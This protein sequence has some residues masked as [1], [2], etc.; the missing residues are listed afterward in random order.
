MLSYT[1]RRLLT[2]LPTL[3]LVVTLSFFLI[4]VAPG[5]PFDLERPLEAKVMENLNRIYRLDRPL[6]EQYVS[7]LG[8][9]L[10]G[11]FGPSFYM[12]DFS[13]RELIA[14]GLPVSMTVGGLALVFAILVGGTIGCVAAFKQNSAIDYATTAVATVGITVPNFVVAPLLQILFGLVLA[15]LPVAGW[16]GGDWHHLLLPVLTLAL[17]QIAI[18]ARLSRA[19]MIEGPALKPYSHSPCARTPRHR[20]LAPCAPECGFA[21]R[22]LSRPR[23]CG[24]PHRFGR[25]RNNL[26]LAGRRPLLC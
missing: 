17:P 5:G 6:I 14:A 3:F 25:G 12:R 7:Y 16:G 11:D 1:L 23:R 22:L 19:S 10:R 13:V 20:D 21:R 8:A 4:R 26:W 2:A 24:R 15:W 9:L 18:I